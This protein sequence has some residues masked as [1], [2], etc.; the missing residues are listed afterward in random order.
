V[1]PSAGAP[2]GGYAAE[3]AA[4]DKAAADAKVVILANIRQCLCVL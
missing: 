2:S 4:A 3:K 1:A